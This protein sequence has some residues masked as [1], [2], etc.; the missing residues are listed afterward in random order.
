MTTLTH[1]SLET[2]PKKL[3]LGMNS[4]ATC[5]ALYSFIEQE[6]G[7]K[8]RG[9]KTKQVPILTVCLLHT[10]GLARSPCLDGV[11]EISM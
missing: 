5:L 3:I 10:P 11:D 1:R 8:P 9:K 2:V 4:L 7:C 6:E